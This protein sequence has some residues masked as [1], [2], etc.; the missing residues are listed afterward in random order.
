MVQHG[1]ALNGSLK[2]NSIRLEGGP[3]KLEKIR[4]GLNPDEPGYVLRLK[5]R[6]AGSKEGD[7]GFA[8]LVP[9]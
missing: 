6:D 2:A 9:C 3:I 1:L 8:N 7:H 4:E 5:A